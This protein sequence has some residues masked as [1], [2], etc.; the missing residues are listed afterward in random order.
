MIVQIGSQ[1][2]KFNDQYPE[3]Q[4]ALD[5]YN[6]SFQERNPNFHVF[7]QITHRDESGMDH[8]HIM[9]IPVSSGNKRGLETKNLMLAYK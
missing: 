6:Q 8:T 3:I 2:D 9:F 5:E 4:K 7:Q 1:D